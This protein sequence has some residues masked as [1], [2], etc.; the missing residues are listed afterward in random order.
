MFLRQ[1]QNGAIVAT[2]LVGELICSINDINCPCQLLWLLYYIMVLFTCYLYS[3]YITIPL[4]HL[5]FFVFIIKA[6]KF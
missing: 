4:H 6:V 3:Y 1:I 5:D 2:S